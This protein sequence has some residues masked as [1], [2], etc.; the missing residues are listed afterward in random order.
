MTSPDP[1]PFDLAAYLAHRRVEIEA[2]LE[3]LLPA[4]ESRLIQAMRHSLLAGGK[5][6]RPVLCLA[7]AE[8]VGG[9]GE[10]VL[11]AACAIELI[12]TYSL[13]HDDLPAMDNDDL[14]RGRPTCHKAFDE[15]TAIL[16]GDAL[17]TMAFEV[18]ATAPF[19][20]DA[21][22]R[23]EIIATLARAAGSAGMIEGQMCDMAAER[24][25]LSLPELRRL[26]ALKTGAMIEAAVEI[27]ARMGGCDAP[28]RDA[29]RRYAQALG[30][31]FQ[32]TDDILNVTGDPRQ[33]GKATGTDQ[34][35]R[36][37]TFPALLGLEPSRAHAAELIAEALQALR[38][39]DMRAEPLRAIARYVLHRRR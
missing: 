27:G 22:L 15:A 24:L 14:R 20:R 17:L 2:L 13:I 4:G 26:H 33:L 31:A 3:R 38:T 35:R 12:H 29:L 21:A 16:A 37:S 34:H 5:R 1:A 18:L 8:A 25:T 7:A 9:S 32:V 6:L 28:A 23:C 30:V 39:F 36:K 19:T 10:T 11:P